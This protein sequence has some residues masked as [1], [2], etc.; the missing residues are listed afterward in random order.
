M[1]NAL[2]EK[3][4]AEMTA[5]QT[6]DCHSHTTAKEEYY[7]M[8]PR[9][10]FDLG[11]YFDR[12]IESVT[13]KERSELYGEC[14][15][16]QEKWER[17]KAVLDKA[18]N[19]S[20]WR[21][22]VIAFQELF[23]LQDE[24]LTDENWQAVN[25]RIK[26]RTA[27]PGWYDYVTWEKCNLRTQVRNMAWFEEWDPQYFTAVLR[28]EP[29]LELWRGEMRSKLEEHLDCTITDLASCTQALGELAEEYQRR[30]A[31]GIKL[32]HAYSRTLR[33]EPVEKARAAMILDRAMRGEEPTPAEIKHLQDYIIFF[34]ADLCSDTGLIF[35]IHTGVQTNWGD[36]PGSNPLL[37]L[38]L[39]HSHRSTRFNLYHAGYPYSR[40]MG[41]LGKHCPNVWLNMAWMYVITM[42]GSR[43]TLSEWIDL[44]PG[45]R[46]LGFG[47]DVLWPELIY[48]HLLMARS[49]LAD[50]LVEK[51]QRDFLSEGAAVELARMMLHDN[52]VAFYGL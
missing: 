19:V 10:L 49:C 23:D 16:E 34:L 30:G 51:V 39:I 18:K 45:Y 36:I 6:V 52:A 44:V 33:S 8:G 43:Q 17:L 42:E 20:Y 21:H 31:V 35:D 7:K 13:G 9:S 25:D 24:D 50:V 29:A 27:D 11:S 47:S 12:E 2:R 22:N 1:A 4:L 15:S 32:A 37:L 26:E 46:L 40:E 3:I 48:S 14:G 41:M 5:L 28:M 38:P